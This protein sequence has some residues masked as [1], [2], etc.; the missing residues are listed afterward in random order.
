MTTYNH[1]AYI[2]QAV[3]SALLQEAPFE[4]EVIVGDDCS[5]DGTTE[6]LRRLEA[7]FA[8]RLR[9]LY[10][11]KN[12]GMM[13]NYRRVWAAAD[14]QY[15]AILE[16]DDYWTDPTKIRRQVEFLDAHPECV[17]A[18][19]AALVFFEGTGVELDFRPPDVNP[20]ISGVE[21]ILREL[22]INTSTVVMR[23]RAIPELPKWADG[24]AVGDWPL[25]IHCA[26]HGKLGRVPGVTT[27]YR[28]HANGLWNTIPA[29]ERV[30]SLNVMYDRVNEALNYQYDREIEVLKSRWAV[31]VHT[32]DAL[33]KYLGKSEQYR[34][35]LEESDSQR[36]AMK[37]ELARLKAEV[38]DLRAKLGA[39][40]EVGAPA[41]NL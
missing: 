34:A 18:Y 14:A 20:E 17:L 10:A 28:K 3:R 1:A 26:M 37:K 23:N 2:E 5:T 16:G 39:R 31:H 7:E 38:E 24:L 13:A 25:Y 19:T 8:P 29:A 12:M 27:A 33:F 15:V 41:S 9:A 21:D 30:R 6:I 35:Q 32:M 36:R 11:A 4:Y 40:P 22:F